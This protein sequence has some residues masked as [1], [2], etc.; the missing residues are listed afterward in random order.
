MSKK[1][2]YALYRKY[3]NKAMLYSP[4]EIMHSVYILK[5]LTAFKIASK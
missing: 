3:F 2:H 5:A 1:K 4:K